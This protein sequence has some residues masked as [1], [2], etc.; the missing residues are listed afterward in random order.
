M[1][2]DVLITLLFATSRRNTLYS[3]FTEDVADG[4]SASEQKLFSSV[5][6]CRIVLN[7]PAAVNCCS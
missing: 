2:K 1:R 4:Y 7:L 3:L 6:W 5:R